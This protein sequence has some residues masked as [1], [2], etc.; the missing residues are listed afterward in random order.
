[1]AKKKEKIPDIQGELI[2]QMIQRCDGSQTLF[3]QG[4]LFDPLKKRL[5]QMALEGELDEH[6]GYPKH[7]PQWSWQ[8][9]HHRCQRSTRNQPA[10]RP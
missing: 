2:K 3:D 7:Q 1:M 4:G 6:L 10:S 8:K 5:I 9:N